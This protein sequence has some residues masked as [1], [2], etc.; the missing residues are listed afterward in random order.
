MPSWARIDNVDA[1]ACATASGLAT[2]ANS[3]AQTPSGNP[4]T[5]DHASSAARRVF[6][7][8]PTPVSVTS[9][10]RVTSPE[11]VQFVMAAHEA[12]DRLG[13]VPLAGLFGAVVYGDGVLEGGEVL[14]GVE[15]RL[16]AQQG[17]VLA[18]RA[19]RVALAAA[20]VQPEHQRPPR[21]LPARM[22]GSDGA[23]LAHRRLAATRLQEGLGVGLAGV[24]AQ[25]LQPRRLPLRPPFVTEL[26]ERVAPPE[27][28]R[29]LQPG[30]RRLG[31][32]CE[33]GQRLAQG[34]LEALHVGCAWLEAQPVAGRGSLHTDRR[35]Q[36]PQ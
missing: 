19:Q 18:R 14:G 15:A 35:R 1:T 9:R 17:P 16:V 34:R 10:C 6:P 29:L 31:A 32:V 27:A 22:L 28:Q 36:P 8:P 13:D 21:P 33:A 5:R 3:T 24:Q 11:V 30:E 20:A 23:G 25:L 7:T 26:R 4:S 2:G 12:R